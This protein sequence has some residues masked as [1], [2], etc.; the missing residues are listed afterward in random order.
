MDPINCSY[1]VTRAS[2][3]YAAI[4][5]RRQVVK[6][7]V[8]SVRHHL[9]QPR[10][11]VPHGP[12]LV[13]QDVGQA[14]PPVPP[15]LLEGDLARLEQA[16]PRGP[17]H[18]EDV[19]GLACREDHLMRRYGDRQP[20]GQRLHHLAENL[21]DLRRQLQPFP[22]RARS[23]PELEPPLRAA[24]PRRLSHSPCP[25]LSWGPSRVLLAPGLVLTGYWRRAGRD[26]YTCYSRP[27]LGDLAGPPSAAGPDLT[28]PRVARITTQ[29]W[30][31]PCAPR[32][33]HAYHSG[34]TGI[35]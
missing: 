22:V 18:S 9:V 28:R 25:C 5:P 6:P 3:K 4:C 19:G 33:A 2:G 32:P 13:G 11:P 35:N 15:R 8:L 17:G 27:L 20:P 10:S 21:E 34:H 7:G 29:N 26:G 24:A 1:P 31:H 30:N 23:C 12:L 16:H 14:H